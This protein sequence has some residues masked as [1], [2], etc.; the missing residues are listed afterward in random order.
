MTSQHSHA[1]CWPTFHTS[2]RFVHSKIVSNRQ[3]IRRSTVHGSTDQLPRTSPLS[4]GL[5]HKRASIISIAPHPSKAI[6]AIMSGS[7][8]RPIQHS[9]DPLCQ[10]CVRRL[11]DAVCRPPPPRHIDIHT[12]WTPPRAD[13]E[14]R[15]DCGRSWAVCPCN[16]ARA[17]PLLRTPGVRNG[18]GLT[19][20][21]LGEAPYFD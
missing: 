5:A 21:P 4:R 12:P 18:N 2:H 8:F 20:Y 15:C 9:R 10:I 7:L 11:S 3:L 13:R 16:P 14:S 1:T 17:G 19:T 6:E